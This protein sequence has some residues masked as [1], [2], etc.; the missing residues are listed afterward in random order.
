[1]TNEQN[2]KANKGAI[3]NP[4]ALY[5]KSAKLRP[6]K[7]IAMSHDVSM[8]VMLCY[9]PCRLYA[10]RNR[11]W[12]NTIPHQLMKPVTA[13][14]FKNQL[15]ASVALYKKMDGYDQASLI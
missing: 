12:I 8:W 2:N 1:M 10:R 14:M 13:V 6:V 7:Y 3:G 4:N 11:K 5:G 9:L 15:K